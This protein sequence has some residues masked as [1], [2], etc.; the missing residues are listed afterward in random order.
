MFDA[1]YNSVDV[2]EMFPYKFPDATVFGNGFE[3]ITCLISGCRSFY[4]YVIDKGSCYVG[5][6]V[7]QEERKIAML[8]L[9]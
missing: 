8:N 5:Y 2:M 9:H 3:A 4:R 7:L 1:L 6:L